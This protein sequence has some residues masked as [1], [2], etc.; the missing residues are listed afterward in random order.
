MPQIKQQV[1]QVAEVAQKSMEKIDMKKVSNKIQKAVQVI[2]NK[3]DS[4]KKSTQNNEIK[5]K[6]N[7]KEAEKQITQLEKEINSLQKK[8][9]SR[10]LK[11]DVTNNTL[12]K[13]KAE[14]NQAVINE[15]PEAGNKRI[16]K[17]TYSRLDNDTNYNS[18]ISQSDKLNNEIMKYN[19]LLDMAK[20]K[21]SELKQETNQTGSSQNKLTAF[22]NAFKGKVEQAKPSISGLKNSFNQ[23]PKIT[24]NITN[25]ISKMGS[26]VKQGLGHIL[27]Y[28]GALLSLRGIYSTLSSCASTWLSSQ[29]AG[30]K[31]LSA[32]IDYMKYSMGS[33]F[34]PVIQY[35][36][37]LIYQLMK[38]IQSVVY[39]LFKVN[40]FANASAKS[41]SNMAGSAKKAKQETKALAGIHD[42]INNV[43]QNDNSNSGSGNSGGMPSFDL[44]Q[45]NNMPNSIIDAIKNG[46]WY[47]VGAT[48]G[49]K[50]NEAMNSIPWDKVQNTAKSIGTNIARLL[51]GFI[52]TINWNQIGNTFAQGINTIIY[53]GYSF[54]TTFD[55]KKFGQSIGDGI[56]GFFKNIDWSTAGKTLGEG[57]K[58]I[59]N[60]IS[61]FLAEVNWIAI[62]EAIKEFIV[63]I[64]WVGIWQTVKETIKNAIG[65]TD[66]LLTGLFGKDTATIIESITTAV[67]GF[68]LV[69]KGLKGVKPIFDTIKTAISGLSLPMVAI[70]AVVT[71]VVYTIITH[72]DELKSSL[73]DTFSKFK[74]VYDEYIAPFVDS[75][76]SSVITLWN[77]HLKPLIDNLSELI[78]TLWNDILKPLIDWFIENVL[79]VLVPIFEGI[80]NT[81][82]K[83]FGSIV[84][85]IS[86]VITVFKGI[87]EFISG[88]F[89]GDW[90]KAW[91]GIKDFFS[92]IWE[93]IKGVISTV[94]NTIKG[95]VETVIN[96]IKAIITTVF[97]VI[98]TFIVNIWNGIKEFFSNIWNGIKNTAVSIFNGIKDTISNVFNTIKNTISNIWN[99]IVNTISN[100]WNTIVNKV[101][102]G[103]SGAWNAITS[104]FG[105]IANWFK[106]IFTNAWQ[107]VKN[108]FS[109]GGKIFDGI[110]EGIVNA[111][112]SVV[113]AIINGINK[114]IAIPFNAINNVLNG[115]RNINILGVEP[116]TWIH[117]FNVPQIPQL[118]KGNVA[119]EPLFAMFGE[120]SGA[121]NNPEITTPQNIMRE[122]FEDVLASKEWNNNSDRPMRV[123]FIVGGKMFVDEI[124]DG[125]NERTRQ[126]G[127]A[128]I[129]VAYD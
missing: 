38:A 56:N 37:N 92:G 101:K 64:D 30:A 98:K 118:A 69:S 109:T 48:I 104:V 99:N 61:S 13:M 106:N 70:I 10:Q 78:M 44:S 123:Q 46:N 55:W 65:A 96:V 27:K 125:I 73:A 77:E 59:F 50:L 60:S 100:V 26:G 108:V 89:S 91:N 20:S 12:D 36:I 116:F 34:A 17:E 80:W 15:M 28:A 93:I 6:V 45:M 43:Q 90:E 117:T 113:N 21:M 105:N 52:A 29:N 95:I 25:N 4:L 127:K 54:I 66:E 112:K 58:G 124:I 51:N 35:V 76:I 83:V 23:M 88:V 79:P 110:K 111:F 47:E 81:I 24:K 2:K 3:I 114:V 53:F 85:A 42:E 107:A 94:W 75:I 84:D 128:Q 71:L 115:I 121:S 33:A 82:S 7:N 122:T 40:I 5:I 87:I 8:I 86:G 41:Y 19:S 119:Y 97:N 63:N 57:I 39:A 68:I 126:T 11:L 120:Y 129:K 72:F 9:T 14:T 62:G 1:I 103:V 74:S 67:G 102:E 31:Q 18:L 22:F 49:Q 32:N 16:T